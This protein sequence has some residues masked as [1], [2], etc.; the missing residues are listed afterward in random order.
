MIVVKITTH[1]QGK[2]GENMSDNSSKN[3]EIKRKFVNREVLC[4]VSSMVD[5]ILAQNTHKAPFCI[6]D[7]RDTTVQYP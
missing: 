5:Y 6:D 2:E 4:N 3:Q 7:I 1:T